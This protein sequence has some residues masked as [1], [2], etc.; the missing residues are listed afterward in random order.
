MVSRGLGSEV[1]TVYEE[2]MNN[3]GIPCLSISCD[4]HLKGDLTVG[5][6]FITYMK[7]RFVVG[8]RVRP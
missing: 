7:V 2:L 6:H 1:R 4:Q 8:S 3:L 5:H